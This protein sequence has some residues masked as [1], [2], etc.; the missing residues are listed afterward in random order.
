MM[1]TRL[2]WL[3]AVLTAVLLG[4]LTLCGSLAETADDVIPKVTETTDNSETPTDPEIPATQ[5]DL[6]PGKS[7]PKGS[8]GGSSDSGSSADDSQ[9]VIPVDITMGP[10]IPVDGANHQ[11]TIPAASAEEW[12]PF[13]ISTAGRMRFFVSGSLQSGMKVIIRN[14]SGQKIY[15]AAYSEGELTAAEHFLDAGDYEIGFTGK[16]M[17]TAYSLII[18]IMQDRQA[19]SG[20]RSFGDA[21]L[22]ASGTEASGAFT[23][24]DAQQSFTG[25]RYYK[26]SLDQAAKVEF[27]TSNRTPGQMTVELGNSEA[28]NVV[29]KK[30]TIAAGTD[31][32]FNSKTDS[33]YLHAGVYYFRVNSKAEG[34]FNIRVT[35]TPE[36]VGEREPNNTQ[37]QAQLSNNILPIDQAA[38][39]GLLNSFDTVDCFVFT[40]TGNNAVQRDFILQ[41]TIPV[42]AVLKRWSGD[43]VPGASMSI[44]GATKDNPK[45]A[46][47]REVSLAPGD[48][49]LEI[50]PDAGSSGTYTVKGQASAS[51]KEAPY[52]AIYNY[53]YYK[54]HWSDLERSFGDNREAYLNHF[55]TCGMHEG[56]QACEEFNYNYY[57]A[58]Y[59]DLRQAF[60]ADKAQY[61][62]HYLKCGKAEKRDARTDPKVDPSD[63]PTPEEA[64]YEAVY[65]YK[66]YKQHPDLA[67]AFGNDRSKYFQHFLNNGLA[68]GRRASNS[69]WITAYVFNYGDLYD[70]FGTNWR[71]YCD[72]YISKG[73]SDG[74]DKADDFLSAPK[75]YTKAETPYINA[76]NPIFYRNTWSDLMKAFGMNRGAY[77]A[78]YLG[79]GLAEKRQ[80]SS[81]FKIDV[82]YNNYADLRKAFGTNWERYCWHYSV[83]GKNEGRKAV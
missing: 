5:S 50:T 56:R 24:L 67:A 30:Q 9:A 3:L 37:H 32:G 55:L 25:Y 65:S 81:E 79:S 35:V 71:A 1:K 41:S 4:A 49:Y 83:C 44:S 70:K 31:E 48:Y 51:D 54:S 11:V 78:H 19:E 66:V 68:E 33:T 8:G 60:G 13:S 39:K 75:T 47:K 63:L 57:Y 2:V 43:P 46:D 15:D 53:Q 45:T 14:K 34:R 73:R 16:N 74:H 21:K 59:A 27:T 52:S 82:Y 10:A 28:F 58:R 42:K 76:F 69:F 6:E 38:V 64:K 61:Y 36:G 18:K 17:Q 77:L 26:L 80:G 7:T 40:V 72:Y 29:D 23:F 22:L 20:H 62:M 12:F